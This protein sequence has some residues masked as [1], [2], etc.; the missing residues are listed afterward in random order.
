MRVALIGPLP[1]PSGGMANL[2]MQLDTI[3]RGEGMEVELIQTN[4]PYWPSWIGRIRGIRAVFRLMPYLYR[5]WKSLGRAQLAH[6]MANSG[7]SWHL[8]AVPAIWIS[9]FRNTPIVVNYH[10]GYANEFLEKQASL[11]SMSMR[12]AAR[13]VVPS[14]FLQKVFDDYGMSSYI[15]PNIIDMTHFSRHDTTPNAPTASPHILVT[16]NLEPVYDI[17]TAIK[18]L[19][20]IRDKGIQAQLVIAGSGPEEQNLKRLARELGVDNFV[21]FTG[22]LDRKEMPRLYSMAAVLLNPSLADNMP[23]SIL[24][25]LSAGVPVVSSNVGGVP[26]LV[27]H[28]KN[29]LLVSP[30]DVESMASSIIRILTDPD[31]SRSLAEAGY[32]TAEGYAWPNV[33]NSLFKVYKDVLGNDAEGWRQ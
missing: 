7:W 25:A 13:L 23:G 11:V 10:G 27:E 20:R 22:R 19:H 33:R 3:L 16:R 15:V 8:Y 2:T 5:L 17:A 1:P 21:T 29:A 4:A 12:R 31:L 6:L 9:H 14:K 18:A 26:Y 28:E 32:K 24:E 30:G